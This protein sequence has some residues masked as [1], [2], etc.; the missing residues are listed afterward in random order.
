MRVLI[1]M[2]GGFDSTYAALK[3][4]EEGTD[5]EGAVLV[6]HGY[7]DV[8]EAK[9][10][11]ERLGI[12][13]HV[14]DC[15]TQ[16]SDIVESNFINE[17]KNGRT[18]NP[19]I[20][21]NREVKFKVL[22]NYAL[23]NGFS[24]IATGHYAKIAKLGERYTLV[25]PRDTAKDQSYMLSRLDQRTLGHLIFPLENEVKAEL[26]ERV[27]LEELPLE[28]K[29]DSQE[30]C[31]IP[32]G[33][34]YDYLSLHIGEGEEGN[35]IDSDGN[36][37]G[38]H[39]GII[40]YTVGQRKGLGI[41]LGKRVFVSRIDAENN[42][43]TLSDDKKTASSCTLYDVVYMGMPPVS[44]ETEIEADVKIRYSSRPQRARVRLYPCGTAEVAF[45]SDAASVTPGQTAVLYSDGAVL[46]S[47]FIS[48]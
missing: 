45:L 37:L 18:P 33:K 38:K 27:R 32:E 25:P 29:K 46:A 8:S 26:R 1:G 2:S 5:V 17:Y 30:I 11:A 47:G 28:D 3:L 4:K 19:C 42:T 41:S 34:Y 23:S 35:F 21:C 44:E 31:F 43:V 12:P 24:A 40:N 20:I 36:I 16:F 7:T 9:R 22:L 15:R 39:K 10:S 13:L 48:L 6:M 14:I